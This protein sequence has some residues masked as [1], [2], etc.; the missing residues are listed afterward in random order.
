MDRLRIV[1]AEDEPVTCLD[2]KEMLTEEGFVVVGDCGDGESAVAL[3]QQLKPDL[4]L[5]DVKMPGMGGIEAAKIICRERLAP[6]LMMT[7][8]SSAEFIDQAAQLGVLAYI[9]KPV[10]KNAL[11]PACHIAVQ[12]YHEFSVLQDE[13]KELSQALEARKVIEK[14]KGLLMKKYVLSEEKAFKKIRQIS[15]EKNRTM[16]EVAEALIMSLEGLD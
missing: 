14:A 13:N 6:V 15:M 8:Y 7:A 16:K 2:I 5:L 1:I 12:R 4:V 3:V 10:T 11:I 9:V